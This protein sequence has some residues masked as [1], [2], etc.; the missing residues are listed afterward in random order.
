MKIRVEL[1]GPEAAK[2]A[3]AL[4]DT[5]LSGLPNPRA[6]LTTWSYDTPARRLYLRRGWRV[7]VQELSYE[8][9]SSLFGLDLTAR[10]A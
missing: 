2:D 1:W 8:W 6:L 10:P 7:L 9:E 5:L 3:E 4:H